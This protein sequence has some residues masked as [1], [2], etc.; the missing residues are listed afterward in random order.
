MIR[1]INTRHQSS[2]SSFFKLSKLGEILKKAVIMKKMLLIFCIVLTQN[3]FTMMQ[4]ITQAAVRRST[5]S[6]TKNQKLFKRNCYFDQFKKEPNDPSAVKRE[7]SWEIETY[8]N[9]NRILFHLKRALENQE[10]QSQKIEMLEKEVAR[11]NAYF[12]TSIKNN[13]STHG[14]DSW[15]N[16]V[17]C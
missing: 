6:P 17:G 7:Y 16:E 1:I 5:F 10:K 13:D 9:T 3:I 15:V 2:L 12:R 11:L 4:R 8:M 14:D